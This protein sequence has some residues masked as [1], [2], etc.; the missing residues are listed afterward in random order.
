MDT[1]LNRTAA[2]GDKPWTVSSLTRYITGVLETD[3]ALRHVWLQ[4]EISNLRQYGSGH[5]YFDLKD[6]QAAIHCVMWRSSAQWLQWQPRNGDMALTHGRI[7]VYA[8]QGAYQLVVDQLRPAGVGDLHAQFEALRDRLKAEGLFDA[9]RKRPLPPFPRVLGIVTSRQAA[10]L[11]DVLNVLHRRYPLARVLLSPCLVQGDQA[12]A[13]I[14][15]AIRRLDARDDVDVIL[16]VRGGGSI[17]DLWAFNDEGVARAIVACRRPVVTGVGHET[18]FTIADFVADVRA[19][20]PSAAAEL[21]VRDQADLRHHLAACDQRLQEALRRRLDRAR[22][23]LDAEERHLHRQSPTTRIETAR[24]QVDD[25]TRRMAQ[26]LA[27]SVALQRSH[28]AGMQ[29]RLAALSPLATLERGYAIVRRHD[30]GSLVRS[31]AQVT[32]GDRLAVQVHDGTFDVQ[33]ETKNDRTL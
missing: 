11:R 15:A 24:Q 23:A 31:V 10:A 29:A 33:V 30:D 22:H 13:Q 3:R 1:E 4:G 6:S 27:H 5:V 12:P 18:D 8:P 9:G 28:V 26:S 16:L 32:A 25:L 20:T 19:P 7:S 14:V 21:V 17:E 2:T